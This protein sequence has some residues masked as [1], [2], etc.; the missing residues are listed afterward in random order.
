MATKYGMVKKSRISEYDNIR[1]TGLNAITLNEGDELIEVKATNGC[2]DILMVSR[3][4][5]AIR[6]AESEVRSVGRTSRGVR[7]MGLSTDDEVVGVQLVSQGEC[8]LTVSEFGMGK[9]TYVSEFSNQHR[10]GM[11]NRCYKVTE[12]TGK[13]IGSKLVDEGR[14]ILLITNE[15]VLIRMEVSGISI[16]GR[17]TSGVKLMDVNRDSNIRVASIAKVRDTRDEERDE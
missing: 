16:I 4:G 1:K 7:G 12:K 14:E 13:L 17:N 15:G 11:G 10:G 3:N 6:F 9:R 8:L 5:Q 2:E